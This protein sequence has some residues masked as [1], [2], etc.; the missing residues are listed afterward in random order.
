METALPGGNCKPHT[1]FSAVSTLP[2][3]LSAWRT[4]LGEVSRIHLNVYNQ[5]SGCLS[6]SIFNTLS[7]TK[8]LLLVTAALLSAL[9][10][11]KGEAPVRFAV[12]GD[13]GTGSKAQYRIAEL[14]TAWHDRLPYEVVITLGD[15]IYGFLW[16]AGGKS[17]FA[18][19]FDKPYAALLKRGVEFRAALG[20]HDKATDLITD[21]ARF[22]IDGEEGY[23]TFTAGSGEDG[24][25]W[26][27][28][29]VLNSNLKELRDTA[30]CRRQCQ[31][32]KQALNRSNAYWKIAYF[33]H[34]MYSTGT[35]G[36][37]LL[38]RERLED[39]LVQAGVD[40]VFAGHEH[41]YQR[42]SLQQGVLHIVSG[43]AGQLR[44][45]DADG[46]LNKAPLP[47]C[48]QDQQP[49]FLLVEAGPHQVRMRAI[50]ADETIFENCTLEHGGEV[51]CATDCAP[52]GR[53]TLR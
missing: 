6:M 19:K 35:H 51:S 47:A 20:N 48:S 34:P 39:I 11:A 5:P 8:S 27:E 45:G 33:H 37:D 36:S 3:R 21:K 26:V 18:E 7:A 22:H 13:Q 1:D 16:T 4:G 41:F 25:P 9:M 53:K 2:G 50:A 12:I 40:I 52:P 38:L 10:G 46:H 44:K 23:Y 31:W 30:Q 15:N 42:F 29:F 24:R 14:M 28:F 49:H 17:R 32:L 43:G